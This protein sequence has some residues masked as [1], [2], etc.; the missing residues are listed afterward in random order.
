M[1]LE[2]GHCLHLQQQIVSDQHLQRDGQAL[3]TANI[4]AMLLMALFISSSVGSD[5]ISQFSSSE[6]MVSVPSLV[7]H[8]CS[9]SSLMVI[10]V[11]GF[12]SKMR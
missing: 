4:L 11:S 12:L 6:S 7:I 9:R 5:T 8:G 10:R 3:T 1:T 2:L